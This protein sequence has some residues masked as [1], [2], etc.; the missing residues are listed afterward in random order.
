MTATVKT[1]PER[2]AI[3]VLIA[4]C[5]LDGHDVGAKVVA[6][7]LIDAGMNV[8]YT[9]LR[10]SPEE[11]ARLAREHEADVVGV[12]ILSGA[13]LPLGQKLAALFGEGGLGPRPLWLMGGNIPKKD[14]L[15]LREMGVA[16]VFQTGTDLAAVVRFVEENARKSEAKP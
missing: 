6:R 10:R 2:R 12:S 3:R 11:I 7:A 1:A 16:G 8:K 14:H 13:H 15:A 9:G 4:K 5:G